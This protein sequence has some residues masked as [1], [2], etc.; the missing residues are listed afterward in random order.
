MDGALPSN[1]FQGLVSG[2]AH[3]V[4]GLDHFVF[5]LALGAACYWFGRRVLGIAAF[6]LAALVGTM[7]HVQQVTLP[8]AELAVAATLVCL[9]VAVLRSAPALK[10]I[11]GPLFFAAA[12]VVHGY[13]YGESIVGAEPAPLAAYL[14]GFT[15]I[16]FAVG[17]GGFALARYAERMQR[18]A[19][20]LRAI[21]GT[22]SIAGVA[23]ALLALTG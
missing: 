8:Y 20:M 4:I 3:P 17:L 7:L 18:S 16:Q 12:G 11:A 1:V 5:V 19:A 13:A 21:G 23:F 9:G 6:L 22:A 2:L 14:V 10:T 15:L